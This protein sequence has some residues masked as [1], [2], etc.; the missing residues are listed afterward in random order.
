MAF[1]LASLIGLLSQGGLGLLQGILTPKPNSFDTAWSQNRKIDPSS[2][3]L[4]GLNK[5][6]DLFGN[7]TELLNK[8]IDLKGAYAQSLPSF[9]GGGMPMAFGFTGQDPA[10]KDPSMLHLA[11]PTGMFNGTPDTGPGPTPHSGNPTNGPTV[12]TAVPRP[13]GQPP[14]T[15]RPPAG[16]D[17]RPPNTIPHDGSGG[18]GPPAGREQGQS[19]G[20]G[21]S[22]KALASFRMLGLDV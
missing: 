11:G 15:S 5:T 13:P 4:G 10:L 17:L 14:G 3:L 20:I 18:D 22:Q 9:A 6:N 7:L 2:Q 16:T 1:D 12:G 8:G 21:D 19:Y